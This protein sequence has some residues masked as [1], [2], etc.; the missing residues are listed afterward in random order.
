MSKEDLIKDLDK[1][2]ERKKSV[3]KPKPKP[4]SHKREA[5]LVEK[6][7][8]LKKMSKEETKIVEV[9]KKQEVVKSQIKKEPL[10]VIEFT[11]KETTKFD[12]NWFYFKKLFLNF[13]KWIGAPY[14]KEFWRK[15]GFVEKE[16]IKIV[17]EVYSNEKPS[18]VNIKSPISNIKP[19]V[20]KP[21]TQNIGEYD[22]PLTPEEIYKLKRIRDILKSEK[23]LTD[24]IFRGEK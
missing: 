16:E 20:V 1:V 12:L 17:K 24:I 21:L 5:P 8:P 19:E 22:K 14:T 4:I 10:P 6:K 15:R 7:K 3:D 18:D 23:D 13:E 9:I 2:A 11:I